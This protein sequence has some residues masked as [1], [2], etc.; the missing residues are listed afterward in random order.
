M[1]LVSTRYERVAPY[2][3]N[4]SGERVEVPRYEAHN[5]I[6]VVDLLTG[7]TLEVLG[8]HTVGAPSLPTTV[9]R[10]NLPTR[11]VLPPTVSTTLH[12][13]IGEYFGINEESDD[14]AED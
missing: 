12:N 11:Y 5:T 7:N 10:N 2:I 8:R 6:S 14:S 1:V 3:G 9:N 13:I 4:F